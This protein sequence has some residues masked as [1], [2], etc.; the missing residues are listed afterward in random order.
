MKMNV[1]YWVIALF[2]LAGQVQAQTQIWN[3]S[4]DTQWYDDNPANSNFSISTAEQLAGLAELVNNGNDFAGKTINLTANILLNDTAN[5]QSWTTT[6][7]GLNSWTPIGIDINNR[8]FSGSFNG[9]GHTVS[10]IFIVTSTTSTGL[11][12]GLFGHVTG[13]GSLKNTGITASFIY[14]RTQYGVS[15]S[16]GGLVGSIYSSGDGAAISNCFNTGKV[17]GLLSVANS[18]GGIAGTV[19]G[20]NA[21]VDSYNAGV[22]SGG[23]AGG[24]AGYVSGSMFNCYNT[25]TINGGVSCA[26]GVAG[27]YYSRDAKNCYNTGSVSGYSRVGGLFGETSGNVADCYN[28]GS[29]EGRLSYGESSFIGGLFGYS[30]NIVITNCYNSGTLTGAKQIVGGL[31][32]FSQGTFINCSN[33]AAVTAVDKVGGLIGEGSYGLLLLASY[34]SGSVN[35]RARIGG[36][37]GNQSGEGKIDSSYNMAT[38][39]GSGD[40][41]GGLVGYTAAANNGLLIYNSCNRGNVVGADSQN[42]MLAGSNYAGGIVGYSSIDGSLTVHNTCNTGDVSGS[43]WVGGLGG[44]TEATTIRN[45]YNAGGVTGYNKLGGLVGEKAGGSITYSYWRTDGTGSLTAA[46]G[47]GSTSTGCAGKTDSELKTSE[48]AAL[49]NGRARAMNNAD[50]EKPYYYWTTDA[51]NAN[52][53]YAVFGGA[54]VNFDVNTEEVAQLTP[55]YVVTTAGGTVTLPANPL[56]EGYV[57]GGWNTKTDA[58]GDA[59]TASTPVNGHITV[60]AFWKKIITLTGLPEISKTYDGNATTGIGISYGEYYYPESYEPGYSDVRSRVVSSTFDNKNVGDNKTITLNFTLEGTDAWRYYFINS[61]NL[62]NGVITPLALTHD[63]TAASSK[64][65]DGTDAVSFTGGLTNVISGDDVTLQ[66]ELQ[67]DGADAGWHSVSTKEWQLAGADA[68]N[69]ILD[70]FSSSIYINQAQLTVTADNKSR[71]EGEANPVFTL[72]YSGFVNNETEAVL[73]QQPEA[74]C[75]AS[76]SSPAGKYEIYVQGGSD[77]NY[78]FVSVNGELEVTAGDGINAV[79]ASDPIVSTQYYNLQGVAVKSPQVGRLYIVKETRQSGKVTTRK[80]IR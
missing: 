13:S 43:D 28:T 8:P 21:I 74:Y 29:V 14:Q 39:T 19:Q 45:C 72:S 80:V 34:N 16:T 11:Y 58:T 69:Y 76:E 20:N 38:V 61:L 48:F 41:L 35:G 5:W 17:I 7:T 44:Y 15:Y 32:G 62:T 77:N 46:L 64:T 68:D 4:T 42:G 12:V 60:Y 10:G 75:Y 3:G 6:T 23:Q 55:G 54:S 37:V 70:A 25:G 30:N 59:F 63:V 26:G 47:A 66:A 36:L 31:S 2:V 49:L 79:S 24:V 65:Y 18:V 56:R 1:F 33:T 71:K 22:V 51:G 52:K 57:F 50:V 9:L 78:Y 27:N 40:N 67:A 53:G 73:D